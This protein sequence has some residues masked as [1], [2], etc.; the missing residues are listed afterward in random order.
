MKR[1]FL[2]EQDDIIIIVIY[3]SITKRGT[4][5]FNTGQR[6]GNGR[7]E[8]FSSQQDQPVAVTWRLGGPEP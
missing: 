4:F 7:E 8:H 1:I 6:G 5:Y 2:T 3:S